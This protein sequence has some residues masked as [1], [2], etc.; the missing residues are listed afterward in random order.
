MKV[1]NKII[2]GKKSF[3]NKCYASDGD[4]LYI[5]SNNDKFRGRLPKN[6]HF[7]ISLK[8]RQ[9]SLFGWV[10]ENKTEYTALDLAR[11]DYESKYKKKPVNSFITD[12]ELI[13]YENFLNKINKMKVDTAMGIDWR[14]ELN[15]DTYK[16]E[17]ALWLH[18]VKFYKSS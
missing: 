5:A 14:E 10:K 12:N 13:E 15:M 16:K 17:K 11:M 9:P 18:I 2:V 7:F 6:G 3:K 1:Y 4:I 8:D